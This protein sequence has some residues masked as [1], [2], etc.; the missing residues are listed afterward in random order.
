MAFTNSSLVTY[1]RLTSNKTSQRKYDIDTITI[2]CYVG[3]VT[4]KQGCDYFATTDRDVS[5]NYVV[6]K[7]GSIGLSVEEKDR[8]WTSANSEND[9]RA[10]TIEV[11]CDSTAPYAVTTAAYNALINLVADICKRNNIKELKWKADK[12]LIGQVDKQNMTVHRWFASTACPGDY[13]YGKHADI[14][15]KVNEKL[16]VATTTATTSVKKELYRIRK[17][18]ADA[19]SQIGAYESLDNAK[20]VCKSGYSVFD[21]NGKV[22]YSVVTA[23]KTDNFLPARGYFKKGDV[24]VNVGKI[25]SFMR[26]TFPLYTSKAALDNIYGDNLIKAV[27]E[28]QRRTGLEPDGYFGKLTLAKLEE[29]GF[30]R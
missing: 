18:W 10:V 19:A 24:S 25:A 2:H 9:H 22:V 16:G 1:K 17:T 11:A 12:S 4:A 28:F 7:D 13:L 21:S 5:S 15:K 29:F 27:K 30:K 8:A 3:Q 23:T 6:G 14:A 20:K 26:K